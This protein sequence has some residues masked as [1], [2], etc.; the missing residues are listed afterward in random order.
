MRHPDRRHRRCL[1]PRLHLA[2]RNTCSFPHCSTTLTWTSNDENVH[3]TTSSSQPSK[4][5]STLQALMTSMTSLDPMTPPVPS[6]LE[7]DTPR[8][9]R[10]GV[11]RWLTELAVSAP[12]VFPVL[13]LFLW[14]TMSCGNNSPACADDTQNEQNSS[15]SRHDSNNPTRPHPA[16]LG[17]LQSPHSPGPRPPTHRTSTPSHG[18]PQMY[19]SPPK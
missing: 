19:R 4:K 2:K 5:R 18:Y 16:H 13:G 11:H 15:T 3:P 14:I 1:P 17:N 12:L 9:H 6:T 7:L 8:H 10:A